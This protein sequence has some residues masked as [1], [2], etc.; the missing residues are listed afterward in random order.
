MRI[1]HQDLQGDNAFDD[2]FRLMIEAVQDYAI[3][4]L[5]PQGT[6]LTWNAGAER[7]KGYSAPEIIG[8]HFSLFY[9]QEE[10][11]SGK[12]SEELPIAAEK[13]TYETEGRR[14]RKDGTVFWASVVLTRLC[15]QRGKIIG[16]TRITRD[17]TAKKQAE[18]R[19]KRK[20]ERFRSAV[21]AS[22]NAL[23]MI[24]ERGQMILV[25]RQAEKLFGYSRDELLGRTVEM[26]VPER[27]R[28]RHSF[29]RRDFFASPSVRHMGAGRELFGL[30]K[31][32]SE[33]AIEIGLNPIDTKDGLIVLSSIIDI[34]ARKSSEQKF[35]LAVEASPNAMVM[36]NH[37][38]T[39]VLAN[40]Q[41][42]RLFGY[43]R[44]ELLGANVEMLVPGQFRA[45][46]PKYREEFLEHPRA[47]PMG[48]GRDLY[49]LRKDGT[50]IPVEIG[51]NPIEME[52]GIYVLSSIVDITERKRAEEALRRYSE[53]LKQSNEELRKSNEELEQYAYVA[54]HDLQEPLR[55]ISNYLDLL[56]L[57]ASGKLSDEE[58]GY[59]NVA[60]EGSIR[61]QELIRDLLRYAKIGA[62]EKEFVRTAMDLVLK[63]VLENLRVAIADAGAEITSGPLPVIYADRSHMQ[64]LLQNLISNALK[65]RSSEP[66]TIRVE[67]EELED[68]WLFSV[69]DNGIGI[70]PRYYGKIFKIFQRLHN[71]NKYS[72]TGIGL[73]VCKKIVETH[74]GKIWV[75]AGPGGKGTTF[76]FSI[77]K[78]KELEP[79][80]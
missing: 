6:I 59:F 63:R 12:P 8:K 53:E 40:S 77:P 23:I 14:V 64:Q 42:E 66:L 37:E 10:I 31:D 74:K 35:R 19:L 4:R 47:R 70:D 45:R 44:S 15:D 62:E 30:R 58:A 60:V 39:I 51:L 32:G 65:Y 1:G 75:E 5:D 29:Y 9:P 28:S 13:G 41:A 46:H 20:E 22:P 2:P 78:N 61:A 27:F 52:D 56:K 72:G 21:E 68:S 3:F 33:V 26:L 25:N 80:S 73:T 17:I 36:V 34:T 16:F 48:A 49:G 18:E 11:L 55:N 69:S 79:A 71:R 43:G 7:I 24:D 57:E 54:A 76:R 67:A 50:Q 38:G